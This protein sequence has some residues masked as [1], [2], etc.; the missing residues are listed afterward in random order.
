MNDLVTIH[1]DNYAAMNKL[2]GFAADGAK[3]TKKTSTLNRLRLW[4][5]PVMGQAEINGKLTNVEVVE[6]GTYRLEVVEGENSTFYYSKNISVRPFMQRFQYRR[7]VANKNPKPNEPKGTF[8]RTIM[9]ISLDDDLKDNTGKFNCGKPSGWIEDFKA[10]PADMQDLIRQIKRVR[11][12]FGIVTMK[13]AV[14]SQGKPVDN[15][16]TPFIWEID[17]KEAFKIIGEEFGKFTKLELVP[18]EHEIV[19]SDPKENKLPNGSSY[20]TPICKAN[21]KASHEIEAEDHEQF[22][23]FLAWVKNFNDY[24]Y[25]EWD[26]KTSQRQEAAISEED[27]DI[28]EDF[29][30]IELEEGAA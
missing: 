4:H 30:D 15:V 17:N 8:H 12:I 18:P 10:L 22:G 1:T 28:V 6:G 27:V 29:I 16:T 14:D 5:Q 3:G 7:Y 13:D 2:M 25:K 9:D 24:I 23:N 19:F 21:L 20:F 26:A 11:V